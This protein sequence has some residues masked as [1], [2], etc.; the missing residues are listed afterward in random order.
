MRTVRCMTQVASSVQSRPIW[1][2]PSRAHTL[3][4]ARGQQDL[5]NRGWG[6]RYYLLDSWSAWYVAGS[7]G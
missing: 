5:D 1:A 6:T 4:N 2:T 7:A 3:D